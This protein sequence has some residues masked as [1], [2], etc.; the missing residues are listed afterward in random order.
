LF[1]GGRRH[2]GVYGAQCGRA[3][4]SRGG[5][6][7]WCVYGDSVL[8]HSLRGYEYAF[9]PC[10]VAVVVGVVRLRCGQ[11]EWQAVLSA[12]SILLRL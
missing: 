5:R 6:S 2:P 12:G 7:R 1:W 3:Q 9:R 11:A 8:W 10:T 4:A